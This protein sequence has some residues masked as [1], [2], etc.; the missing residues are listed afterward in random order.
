M[1]VFDYRARNNRGEY[2]KGTID[3]DSPSA[4]AEQLKATGLLPLDIKVGKSTEN[5]KP[6]V[7]ST[8]SERRAKNQGIKPKDIMLFSRQMSTLQKA[9]VPI[10]AALQGLQA[11][12]TKVAFI[13]VIR[14]LRQSLGSGRDLASS[15]VPSMLTEVSWPP[16]QIVMGRGGE[17]TSSSRATSV[18]VV[19]QS[20]SRA[21]LS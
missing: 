15:L 10:L 5:D 6:L 3:G 9:G 2:G 4:V 18:T 1:P 8:R 7:L 14:D 21:A 12:T 19:P 11:S 16:C 17:G 13:G 20:V